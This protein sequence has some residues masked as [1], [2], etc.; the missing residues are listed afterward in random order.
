[1][2]EAEAIAVLDRRAVRPK[3]YQAGRHLIVTGNALLELGKEDMRVYSLRNFCVKR[4]AN[5]KVH[6]IAIQE[7]V[8]FD[9][10]EPEVKALVPGKNRDAEVRLY[11]VI[12]RQDNGSYHMRQAVD[13]VQLPDDRFGGKWPEAKLPYRVLAW[14]LAD[15]ADYATGLVEDYIG[16][17]EAL[18][19]LSESSLDGAVLTTEMRWLLNPGSSM[20]IQEFQKSRNGDAIPGQKDDLVAVSGGDPRSIEIALKVIEAYSQRIARGF[21]LQSALTR[22]AERV[23]AEEVR[24]LAMELETA[25]GGVYSQLGVSWQGPVAHWCLASIDLSVNGAD[26]EVTVI[27][28]LEALTRN[29]QLEK[30][31]AA[32]GDLALLEQLPDGLKARLNYQAIAGFV[33]AGRGINL[34][35]FLKNDEQ[36]RKEQEQSMRDQAATQAGVAAGEAT[37]Q[38]N[39]A[40]QQGTPVQ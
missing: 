9:E 17:F 7:C 31:R 18:S 19:A 24:A 35:P 1:L 36:V 5:G 6:T 3:L 38:A 29:A 15:E 22:N 26:F 11:R 2:K 40:Q 16:D 33:G 4:M 13:E 21:L 37:A 25:H 14:D 20:T 32:L 34:L 10:L 8:K 39:V 28:G 12:C 27:T 30:L 23:T